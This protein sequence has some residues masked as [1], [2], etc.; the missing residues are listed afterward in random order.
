MLLK[1]EHNPEQKEMSC[2]SDLFIDAQTV[3]AFWRRQISDLQG[4]YAGLKKKKMF[5]KSLE[6]DV[7]DFGAVGG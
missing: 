1:G 2:S 7:H 6:Q 5:F 4:S 3:E